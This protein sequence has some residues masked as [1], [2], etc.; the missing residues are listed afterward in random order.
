MSSTVTCHRTVGKSTAIASQFNLTPTA[1]EAERHD[2]AQQIRNRKAT[3]QLIYARTV[4]MIVGL[5]A[6]AGMSSSTD[7]VPVAKRRIR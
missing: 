6:V 3:A 2:A 4:G 7:E 5:M 1:S